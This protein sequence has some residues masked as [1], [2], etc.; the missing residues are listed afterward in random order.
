V[1]VDPAQTITLL[2]SAAVV[3]AQ[4][5][6]LLFAATLE[7]PRDTITLYPVRHR[8][9]TT[10]RRE[11]TALG[12][13]RVLAVTDH[14]DH[15]T[16]AGLRRLRSEFPSLDILVAPDAT[17]PSW[18]AAWRSWLVNGKAWRE[19]RSGRPLPPRQRRQVVYGYHHV[20]AGGGAVIDGVH[21][22]RT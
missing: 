8:D 15:D 3:L 14:D 17:D 10:M 11:L 19:P 20:E 21:P 7:A 18:S 4:W 9:E 1:T 6:H 5:P 16:T 13:R 12:H 22:A 2:F